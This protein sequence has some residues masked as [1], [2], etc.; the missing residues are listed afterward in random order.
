MQRIVTLLITSKDRKLYASYFILLFVF[1]VENTQKT[2]EM[3]VLGVDSVFSTS[4][5]KEKVA[6]N[7]NVKDKLYLDYTHDSG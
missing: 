3:K 5:C 6:L 2:V 4:T 7:S 1:Q